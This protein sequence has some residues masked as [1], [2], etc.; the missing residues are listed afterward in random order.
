MQISFEQDMS[1]VLS[2]RKID[3]VFNVKMKWLFALY[4]AIISCSF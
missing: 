2:F 3:S 4:S 1:K